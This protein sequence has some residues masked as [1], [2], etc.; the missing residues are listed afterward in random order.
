MASPSFKAHFASVSK[1]SGAVRLDVLVEPDARAGL[2]NML[3]ERRL[4]HLKGTAAQDAP[5]G[6]LAKYGPLDH[7]DTVF[8]IDERSKFETQKGLIFGLV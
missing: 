4:A 8:Q 7:R 3:S 6:V 5:P 1:H 2:A